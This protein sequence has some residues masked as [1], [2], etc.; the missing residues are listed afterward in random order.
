V[1][2]FNLSRMDD[3]ARELELA[4]GL[5]DQ[6]GDKVGAVAASTFLC[7]ARPTDR[8]VPGWLAD[9]LEFADQ[10]GDR[11]RQLSTLT[12]LAWHHFIRSL[13]GSVPQTAEAEGFAL[14]LAELAEDLGAFDMAVHGRSLLAIM[15]RFSGRLDEAARHAEVLGRLDALLDAESY[16]WLGRAATF[17][18]EAARGADSLAPPHAPVDSPDPVVAMA[19]LVIEAELTADGRVAEAL[20]RFDLAERPVPGPFGDLAGVLVGLALVLAG[21]RAEALPWVERA[22]LAARALEAPPSAAAALAL[23]AEI[24][25]DNAGLPAA[26]DSASSIGDALLLRAH[27][28]Q[29]DTSALDTLRRD[30]AALAMPGLVLGL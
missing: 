14:R 27:A 7:L 20:A 3:S 18:V 1:A 5:F 16:P 30:A 13:W 22:S 11:S 24:T 19:L 29:G 6:V 10:A 28:G 17:V 4:L 21:R 8:R 9:A 25:G 26:P 23:R 2:Y 12:T 15:A